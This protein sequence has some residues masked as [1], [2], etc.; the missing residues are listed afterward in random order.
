M[1]RGLLGTSHHCVLS[2]NPELGVIFGCV[3]C[4]LRVVSNFGD[5]DCG[6]GKIHT[7]A[8]ESSRRR[9][10]KGAPF[11][12]RLL[13]ISRARVCI[14]PAPQSPSPKLETTRSLCY[15]WPCYGFFCHISRSANT[16]R[17]PSEPRRFSLEKMV[18]LRLSSSEPSEALN[19]LRKSS[20]A[21][22][23]SSEN[24]GRPRVI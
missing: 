10:T 18:A 8:R 11:A 22:E 9:D 23:S 14:L 13:E 15:L 24:F 2:S 12:S 1:G 16:G 6:A 21:F 5:C 20:E 19:N 3:I 7:R 4:R 17:I